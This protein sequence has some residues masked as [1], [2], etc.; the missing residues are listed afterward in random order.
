[1]AVWFRAV[2]GSLLVG[3]LRPPGRRAGSKIGRSAARLAALGERIAD[4]SLRADGERL[5]AMVFG[6]T[7]SSARIAEAEWVIVAYLHDRCL[8]EQVELLDAKGEP[9]IAAFRTSLIRALAASAVGI[10]LD[11]AGAPLAPSEPYPGPVRLLED[12]WNRLA[13]GST[14]PEERAERHPP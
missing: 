13:A 3:R 14:A 8:I 12:L 2:A 1:M 5:A 10:L 6:D 9:D 11:R 4:N 7:A